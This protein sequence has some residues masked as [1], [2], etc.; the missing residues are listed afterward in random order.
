MK[1]DGRPVLH[2]DSPFHQSFLL[3]GKGT[4]VD[5]SG[6]NGGPGQ[7]DSSAAPKVSMHLSRNPD[8]LACKYITMNSSFCFDNDIAGNVKTPFNGSAYPHVPGRDVGSVDPDPFSQM[9]GCC[10]C[11]EQ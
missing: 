2:P 11:Y 1:R 6:N 8:I 10:R 5:R 3:D 4:G 9:I 7:I